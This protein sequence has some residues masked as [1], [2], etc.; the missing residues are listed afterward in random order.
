MNWYVTALRSLTPAWAS[1]DGGARSARASWLSACW[2]S[3]FS[4]RSTKR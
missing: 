1:A 2:C 4:F 3:S